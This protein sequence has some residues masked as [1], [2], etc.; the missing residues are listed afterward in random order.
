MIDISPEATKKQLEKIGNVARQGITDVRRSV[1]KLRP[2]ALEKMDLEKAISK[3]MEELKNTANIDIVFK[4]QVHPLKFLEDEEEVIYRVVQEATTN[5]VR[6][7]HA[8]KIS[9]EISKKEEWLTIIVKDNGL[10]CKEV[11]EGFGL[12]HMKERLELL[13]GR[14]EYDGQDGFFI[15]ASIPIRWGEEFN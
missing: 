4:N 11:E 3:M 15:K 6:H 7:G 14:L 8:D 9:I 13:N 5:S 2:D 10:G 12:K 1:S